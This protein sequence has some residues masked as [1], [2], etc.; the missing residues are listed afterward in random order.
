MERHQNQNA[1]TCMEKDEAQ[2]LYH[3]SIE[4]DHGGFQWFQEVALRKHVNTKQSWV[5]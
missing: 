5:F 1:F 3:C 2:S 4:C